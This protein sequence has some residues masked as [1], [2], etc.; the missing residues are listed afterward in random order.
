LPQPRRFAGVKDRNLQ[1]C[2]YQGLYP[3][4]R[5]LRGSV[6]ALLLSDVVTLPVPN[7]PPPIALEIFP[8]GHLCAQLKQ[9][10]HPSQ[11][12]EIVF[13]PLPVLGGGTSWLLYA[14]WPACAYDP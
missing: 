6:L 3:R 11:R 12:R 1:I 8:A 5:S 13:A 14:T 4:H 9:E 10:W 2:V 7:E